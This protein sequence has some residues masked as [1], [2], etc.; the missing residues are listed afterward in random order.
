MK[1]LI[2][3]ADGFGFTEG[4]NRGIIESVQ[5]GIVRSTSA[6]ANMPAIEEVYDFQRKYPNVSIGIHFNLSVGKPVANPKEIPSLVNKD[7]EF[8]RDEFVPRLLT[9]K[10]RIKEMEY[11]LESQ[12]KRLK[13]LG[14]KISHFDGHQNKHLYPPFFH[15]VM[16]IAKRHK[17]PCMRTHRRYIFMMER[18]NTSILRYYISN[19]IRFFSHLGGRILTNYASLYGF[20]VADRLITPGYADLTHKSILATWLRI[21]ETLPEGI[22]EI[23]CHPGYPDEMLKKYAKYVYERINEIKILT[24]LELRLALKKWGIELISFK[25]L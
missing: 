7:G 4:I 23:Y 20:K 14:V 21:M 2:V 1:K 19:P 8:W 3:N 25:D 9:G 11:E 6:L 15:V 24:S 22:N 13:D 5:N 17:I 10:I 12:V 16:K 18:R